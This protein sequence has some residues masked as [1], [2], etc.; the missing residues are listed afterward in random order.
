MASLSAAFSACDVLP[1]VVRDDVVR[2]EVAVGVDAE[3]APL[4][5]PDLVGNLVGRLGQ[6]ADV[7]VARL[8][9]VPLLE[10]ALERPRLRGRLDDHECFCHI[11]VHPSTF[12]Q[13]GRT[14]RRRPGAPAPAVPARTAAAAD[15]PSSRPDRSAIA[16]RSHGFARRQAREHRIAI[17]LAAS[18][19]ASTPQ[20]AGRRQSEL[21]QDIV[22]GLHNLC[23]VPQQRVRRRGCGRSAR[24]PAPPARRGPARAR[25]AP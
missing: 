10:K 25:S 4:L 22:R 8:D 3:P 12:C 19:R 1:L 13:P 24:C 18:R 6:I 14:G 16:S 9:P 7:A 5:L 15:A 23:T 17:G 20:P 21:L 11:L 2:L